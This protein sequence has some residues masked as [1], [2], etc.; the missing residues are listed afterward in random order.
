LA[1]AGAAAVSAPI[2]FRTFDVSR[3]SPGTRMSKGEWPWGHLIV[4]DRH[5]DPHHHSFVLFSRHLNTGD[6]AAKDKGRKLC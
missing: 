1:S 5:S 3:H 2:E 6:G 4:V